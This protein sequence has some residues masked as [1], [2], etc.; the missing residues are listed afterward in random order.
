M[1]INQST[2]YKPAVR[3]S[4]CVFVGFSFLNPWS[5]LEV[6]MRELQ[7]NSGNYMEYISIRT[8]IYAILN[9]LGSQKNSTEA[10]HHGAPK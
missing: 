2:R 3:S 1:Q 6:K 4:D 5:A 7:W 8:L 9:G 10:G